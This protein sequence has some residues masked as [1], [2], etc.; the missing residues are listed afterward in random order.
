LGLQVDIKEAEE[1][2]KR[3]GQVNTNQDNKPADLDMPIDQSFLADIIGARYEQI[4]GL[5]QEHLI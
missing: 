4:F 2:K 3:Y 5:F 1:V